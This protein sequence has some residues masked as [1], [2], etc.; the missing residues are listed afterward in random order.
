MENN[1]LRDALE[2]LRVAKEESHQVMVA[3]KPWIDGN[4]D[5]SHLDLAH[6]SACA[7]RAWGAI[8]HVEALVKAEMDPSYDWTKAKHLDGCDFPKGC[9]LGC[10]VG[11]AAS[12][13][14]PTDG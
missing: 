1:K 3:L 9:A 10:N 11:K 6:F 13:E 14:V 7:F 12:G 4:P 5:R 2:H 8:I